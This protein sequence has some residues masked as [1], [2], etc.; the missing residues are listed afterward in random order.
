M[1]P[2]WN[3]S[4]WLEIGLQRVNCAVCE[5]R[6]WVDCEPKWISFELAIK[7]GGLIEDVQDRINNKKY[8]LF[9]G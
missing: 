4:Y 6:P 5:F 7:E 3:L 1:C 8:I 9:P 2:K